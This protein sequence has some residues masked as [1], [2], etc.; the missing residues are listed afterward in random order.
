MDLSMVWDPLK[1]YL[2]IGW[3]WSF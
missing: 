3:L 1:L 2:S